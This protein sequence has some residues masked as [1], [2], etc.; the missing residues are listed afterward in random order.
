MAHDLGMA[1]GCGAALA[2]LR[3]L[4]SEPFGLERA[5]T[6]ADLDACSREEVLERAGV[7]LDQALEVLPAVLLDPGA[8][9]SVGAGGRPAVTP[10]DA[11][12]GAGPRSIVFRDG[13]GMALALGELCADAADP[14]RVL[15]CPRVVFPWTVGS[16]R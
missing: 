13:A 1:L 3:R 16:G 4:R 9:A 11:P 6:L 8:A 2:S 14:H 5:V 15:A 7:P 12:I 10:G